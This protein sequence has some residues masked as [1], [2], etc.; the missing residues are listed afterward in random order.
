MSRSTKCE[1]LRDMAN[2]VEKA[3]TRPLLNKIHKLKCQD[4]AKKYL[5]TDFSKVLWTDEMRVTLDGDGPG[6]GSLIDTGYHFKSGTSKVEEGYWY[7]LLSLRM[8]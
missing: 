4:W 6:I 1:V 7:E 2:K 8:S 3:E 5:L